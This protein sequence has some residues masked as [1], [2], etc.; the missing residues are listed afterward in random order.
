MS[1]LHPLHMSITVYTLYSIIYEV[2][3]CISPSFV[4]IVYL[5]SLCLSVFLCCS[6]L[7]QTISSVSLLFLSFYLPNTSFH[8]Y[9]STYTYIVY[10]SIQEIDDLMVEGNKSR[11]VAATNMNSESSRSHAVFTILITFTLKVKYTREILKGTFK[12]V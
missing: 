5:F 1:I 9:K 4:P 7:K 3:Y 12:G 6:L 2:L 8:L 10:L 11:T